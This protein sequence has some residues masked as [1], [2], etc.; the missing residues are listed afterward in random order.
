MTPD[1]ALIEHMRGGDYRACG[2]FVLRYRPILE[3]F[4]RKAK[5]PP[6]DWPICVVEVLEDE[7]LRLSAPGVQAPVNVG[8]YLVRAVH[9]RY[10]RLKRAAMGRDRR[11]A[12]AS[13]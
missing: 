5:I 2:E 11:Y 7:V 12:A 10:L 4:A 13:E 6:C 9:H 1:S 8:A 3:A